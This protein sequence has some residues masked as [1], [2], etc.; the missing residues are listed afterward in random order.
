MCRAQLSTC[1]GSAGRQAEAAQRS[2]RLKLVEFSSEHVQF[3]NRSTEGCPGVSSLDF[4][5][6][7]PLV[8]PKEPPTPSLYI[9]VL[10]PEG[11]MGLSKQ[12]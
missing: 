10:L 5:S 2:C 3:T 12:R 1:W 8:Q 6:F 4:A 9:C 11:E 7:G